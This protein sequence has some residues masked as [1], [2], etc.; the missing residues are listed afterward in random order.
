MLTGLCV[1]CQRQLGQT[2]VIARVNIPLEWLLM[3]HF[4]E[5]NVDLLFIE[6]WMEKKGF[7]T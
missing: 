7:E 2:L 3:G 1:G 6:M 5:E 4:M